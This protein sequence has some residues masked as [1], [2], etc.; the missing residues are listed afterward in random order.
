MSEG[1]AEIDVLGQ[2]IA[3]RGGGSPDYVQSLAAYLEGLIRTV[4][5]QARVQDPTRAS[6]L[7]GL[8]VAD[9][10][11]RAREREAGMA[12]RVDLLLGELDQVLGGR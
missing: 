2:R 10:L 5:E 7:A 12:A 11:F 4:G 8:H 6:V 3:V 1:R 9:E